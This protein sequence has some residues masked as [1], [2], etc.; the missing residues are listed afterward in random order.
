[1]KRNLLLSALA[2]AAV[3]A[4]SLSCEKENTEVSL[5]REVSLDLSLDS[6]QTRI[7][8]TEQTD[9]IKAAW[10][11]G[12]KVSVTWGVEQNEFE[13]FEVSAIK[14]GGRTAVFTN[15][16]STMPANCTIGIYYPS[17]KW[18]NPNNPYWSNLNYFPDKKMDI[19]EAGDYAIYAACG[20]EVKDGVVSAISMKPQTSFI[21]IK[22]ETVF[23]DNDGLSLT[24]FWSGLHYQFRGKEDKY[25]IADFIGNNYCDISWNYNSPAYDLYLP[26][27]ADGSEQHLNIKVGQ[28]IKDLGTKALEPGKIYDISAKLNNVPSD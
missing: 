28:Y 7:S 12:D 13:I 5:T 18:D 8:M 6:P 2:I 11:V 3:A 27:L 14:D 4:L 23:P 10:E 15:P 9:C 26:F 25:M 22:K 19:S 21:R 20:I 24:I 16:S 17:L 1:M